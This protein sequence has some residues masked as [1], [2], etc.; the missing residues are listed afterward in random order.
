MRSN[1]SYVDFVGELLVKHDS[2]VCLWSFGQAIIVGDGQL[3][4]IVAVRHLCTV[5]CTRAIRDAPED[6]SSHIQ[7]RSHLMYGHLGW[8]S[9]R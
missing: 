7:R 5:D 9:L 3:Y 1:G 6:G 4:Q 2:Q 8:L